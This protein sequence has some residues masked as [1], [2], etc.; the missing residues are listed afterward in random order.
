[1]RESD[2]EQI[3]L[4][5]KK[6]KRIIREYFDD[7]SINRT[8]KED[9]EAKEKIIADEIR[10]NFMINLEDKRINIRKNLAMLRTNYKVR[11]KARKKLIKNGD[12]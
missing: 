4:M 7:L 3:N 2:V 10:K 6:S 8:D 1:M 12:I 9:R 11:E 5:L